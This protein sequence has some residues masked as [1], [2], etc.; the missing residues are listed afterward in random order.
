LFILPVILALLQPTLSREDIVQLQAAV[1]RD[2]VTSSPFK[3]H[4]LYVADDCYDCPPSATLLDISAEEGVRSVSI[5]DLSPSEPCSQLGE[6]LGAIEIEVGTPVL[7]PDG[8]AS[9]YGSM[10]YCDLGGWGASFTFRREGGSWL[11]L[12]GHISHIS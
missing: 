11:Q 8:T 4:I 5:C 12:P 2:L 3:A 6:D 9:V 1:V 10:A 7:L